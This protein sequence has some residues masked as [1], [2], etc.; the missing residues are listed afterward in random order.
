MKSTRESERLARRRRPWI[1]PPPISALRP[2]VKRSAVVTLLVIGAAVPVF[3]TDSFTIGV[4]TDSLIYV[5][6]ALS[7]D[8]SVGQVGSFSLA[9]PAFFGVGAYASAILVA[10]TQLP[11]AVQ[12]L[13]ATVCAAALAFLIGIPALRLSH[14]T[15]GMATLGFALI[16]QLVALNA[17]EVTGGPL[18]LSGLPPLSVDSLTSAGVTIAAQEYYAFLIIAVLV[19]ILIRALVTSRIGRAYIA[20]REDEPM[21]MAAGINPTAYRM[22]AF[23]IGAGL[24][25]LLGSFYAHYLSIVCP[26]NLGISYTISLLVI[27][28][29]GGVGGFWGIILA[30][31]VFTAIPEELQ[32]DPTIRLIVYGLV[33]LVGVTLMPHGFEGVFEWLRRR[34]RRWRR[35]IGDA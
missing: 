35:R 10:H 30:A 17:V 26:S 3:I 14:L 9:H 33:L 2:T 19:A 28:F 15:F 25:G 7:Y 11:L 18:C 1:S 34:A 23:V 16:A 4:L 5:V 29:L 12:A 31:F 8:L 20:I 13:C 32:V 27:I 21:A 6:L 24:A 22:S